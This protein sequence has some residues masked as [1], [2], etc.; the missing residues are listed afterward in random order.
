VHCCVI[1]LHLRSTT[2]PATTILSWTELRD[3]DFFCHGNRSIEQSSKL[4]RLVASQWIHFCRHL[5]TLDVQTG[6]WWLTS[7]DVVMHCC[8]RVSPGQANSAFHLSGVGK[9]G[10][11]SAGKGK[12]GM[13]HSVSGWM[14][15]VQV[16][17]WDPLRTSVIPER[18]RGV[19]TTRHYTNQRLPYLTLHT[20][21]V[22]KDDNGQ[23]VHSRMPQSP[24][25]IICYCC[26]TTREAWAGCTVHNWGPS[27]AGKEE[28]GVVHSV[29]GT[30]G[31]QVKLRSFENT[32]HT[33]V[34]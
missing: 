19:I 33:W 26:V 15:G 20:L 11:A 29:R 8:S 27:S 30:R 31:V 32:C 1:I 34:P 2:G 12:A 6:I 23:V 4:L 22:H 7:L 3:H 17:L 13:V 14:R 25:R 21:N 28:A 24:S 18:L 10:P 5:K 16:K 9:W